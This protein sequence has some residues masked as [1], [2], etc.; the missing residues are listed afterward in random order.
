MPLLSPIDPQK[1]LI[2]VD[3][4]RLTRL[5]GNARELTDARQRVDEGGFPDVGASNK[6][7]GG[8]ALLRVLIAPHGGGEVGRLRNH[9]MF[10]QNTPPR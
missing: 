9:N 4:L 10:G 1:Q 6:S 5:R 3:G 8:T 7:N 2:E